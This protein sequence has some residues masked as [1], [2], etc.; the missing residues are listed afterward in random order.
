MSEPAL[1][2]SGL[3]HAYG[4]RPVLD[5]AEWS[6]AAP[7]RLRLPLEATK[8]TSGSAAANDRI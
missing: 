3:R 8:L 7:S 5:L 4:G 1:Q 2:I 6:V